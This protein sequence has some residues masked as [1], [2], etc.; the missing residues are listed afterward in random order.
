M[1]VTVFQYLLAIYHTV[2]MG[3]T[4]KRVLIGSI[5]AQP[6][7]RGH[8][9][10]S[11]RV[12]QQVQYLV[13]RQARGVVGA[14]VLVIIVPVI[15]VQP[16][17]GPYPD[18]SLAVF[19]KGIHLLVRQGGGYHRRAGIFRRQAV[20]QVPMAGG[21]ENREHT[22]EQVNRKDLCFHLNYGKCLTAANISRMPESY[23][24]FPPKNTGENRPKHAVGQ[25][26]D[27]GDR[28][29]TQVQALCTPGTAFWNHLPSVKKG[30]R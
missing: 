16:P 4:Y 3:H 13:V 30:F 21:S 27:C 29:W 20:C 11:P 24:I 26:L 2:A 5:I 23:C 6:A 14:E 7:Y 10:P 28:F 22:Q 25:F 19:G 8:P 15:S 17:E 9:Q 18:A 1:P 12:A